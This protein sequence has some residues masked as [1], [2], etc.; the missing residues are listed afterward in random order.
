[1]VFFSERYALMRRD[2]VLKRVFCLLL[3][4]MIVL[5]SCSTTKT[6]GA[7]F[8]AGNYLAENYASSDA[9]RNFT[10]EHGRKPVVVIGIVYSSDNV[11][12]SQVL[13]GFQ[14]GL[15]SS[16][17]VE[18]ILGSSER[19]ILR[20]ERID[21]LQ[22]GN[23]DQI[24][25]LA[26]ESAADFF[27]R[28]YV[29]EVDR[30]YLVSADMVDVESGKII[31]FA[32]NRKTVSLAVKPESSQKTTATETP[33]ATETP[34]KTEQ[35]Q[36]TIAK[37]KE[38]STIK[39]LPYYV[40][41]DSIEVK[42]IDSE[43]GAYYEARRVISSSD[44]VMSFTW[45]NPD[46]SRA[47]RIEI[48]SN[49][50]KGVFIDSTLQYNGGSIYGADIEGGD[51]KVTQPMRP[52][53]N[54][55]YGTMYISTENGIGAAGQYVDDIE[56][57]YRFFPVEEKYAVKFAANIHT[58]IGDTRPLLDRVKD[59]SINY[60]NGFEGAYTGPYSDWTDNIFL[61]MLK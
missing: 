39:G 31:W 23:M 7:A 53:G 61:K 46:T 14:Q 56:V 29:D 48:T 50:P 25:S 52:N 10:G 27:G 17:K 13:R 22:W 38:T 12:Y 44:P 33:K 49:A 32:Q 51:I 24:K 55:A 45:T 16:G 36:G 41:E 4:V 43:Y 35:T 37:K 40:A 20:G 57:V 42:K 30:G 18:L 21:Q 28:V 26:N 58:N 19:D 60:L 34:A 2:F 8:D 15:I 5:V 9:I 59:N 1:M 11:D 47:Y 6:G 3:I 54:T